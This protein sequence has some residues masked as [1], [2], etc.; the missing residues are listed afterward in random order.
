MVSGPPI[1]WMIVR[2]W[3]LP[4]FGALIVSG[5]TDWLDG[6][7]ARKMGINSV[8]VQVL[9]SCV[10]LAMVGKD[11]LDPMVVALVVLSDVALIS[12]AVYKRASS[13]GWEYMEELVELA[14]LNATHREKVEPLF[15]S[16]H[17][18]PV[19]AAFLQPES[20]SEETQAYVTCGLVI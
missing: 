20:G 9:I 4:F 3:Y 5:A 7:L 14:N 2:E 11:L 6:F 8:L 18:F 16:E 1:G 12:G 15:M 17:S 13:L 10:A 19:A